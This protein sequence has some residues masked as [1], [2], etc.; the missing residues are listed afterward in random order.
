MLRCR[1]VTHLIA[2]DEFEEAGWWTRFAIRVHLLMCRNCREYAAQLRA[3]GS[4]ARL[5][6]TDRHDSGELRVIQRLEQNI[7]KKIRR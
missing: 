1:E 7:L 4:A 3:I 6:L 5:L 2:A